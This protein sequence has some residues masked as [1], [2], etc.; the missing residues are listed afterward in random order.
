MA[1]PQGVQFD[2][3]NDY[4]TRGA[5]LSGNANSKLVT[6]AFWFRANSA[7]IGGNQ[8]IFFSGADLLGTYGFSLYR[9]GSEEIGVTGRDASGNS[10]LVVLSSAYADTS[11][12]HCMFSFDMSDTGKRHLY[13]D[14]SSD[15]NVT[16]YTNDTLDFTQSEH[17]V[18]AAN[19]FGSPFGLFAGD[20]ADFWL[21]F[22]TYIDLSVASNR[23]KFVGA[24]AASSVD[25][26]SDGSNPT[27]AAPIVFLSG[28]VGSWH[29]NDGDG[30]GFTENGA[31]SAAS[32]DPPDYA[33][34]GG[35]IPAAV[36]YHHYRRT[37]KAR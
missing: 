7:T 22:G 15:L 17:Y 8:N 35:S 36:A 34:A 28:A 6:G 23:R 12:H 16:T 13:I 24:S 29:T 30:G 18:G 3:S 37:L 25:L 31:L 9:S 33:A 19:A 5:D 21:D 32:A 11:W 27:G 20:L 2:G 10:D 26:G 14:D 1:A 4:L